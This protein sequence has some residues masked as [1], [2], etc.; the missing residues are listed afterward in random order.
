[1]C[2]FLSVCAT[3]ENMRVSPNAQFLFGAVTRPRYVLKATEQV[4]VACAALAKNPLDPFL[5]PWRSACEQSPSLPS[6]SD[7]LQ[8]CCRHLDNACAAVAS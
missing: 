5:V 7:F 6:V 1:M 3:P 4:V 2:T 8:V